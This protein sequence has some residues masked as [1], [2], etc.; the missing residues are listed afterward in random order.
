M[1]AV[2]YYLSDYSDDLAALCE[3]AGWGGELCLATFIPGQ[4]RYFPNA[5]GAFRSLSEQSCFLLCLF[6]EVI[7][8][9]AKYHLGMHIFE[10]F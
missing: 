2:E 3:S 6:F 1:S 4:N 5:S 10:R 7:E 8:D 9:Q